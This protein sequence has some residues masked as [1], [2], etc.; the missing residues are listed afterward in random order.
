MKAYSRSFRRWVCQHVKGFRALVSA[1]CSGSCCRVMSRWRCHCVFPGRLHAEHC[2]F[3]HLI[4]PF[5]RF[6]CS[7]DSRS[8]EIPQR[9][10]TINREV[11]DAACWDGTWVSSWQCSHHSCVTRLQCIW[12]VPSNIGTPAAVSHQRNRFTLVSFNVGA[13]F[14]GFVTG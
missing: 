1:D 5:N 6:C 9:S 7:C 12:R 2:L 11:A 10:L 3:I 13:F 8:S 14:V 4:S